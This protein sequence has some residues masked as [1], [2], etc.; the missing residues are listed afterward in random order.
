VH[1]H[2]LRRAYV[3]INANKGVPLKALQES[4]GHSDLKTTSDYCRTS[5]EEALAIMKQVA[6]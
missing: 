5:K 6:W 2:A 1:P 3:T 4:C